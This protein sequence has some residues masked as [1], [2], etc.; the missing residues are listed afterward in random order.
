M[1]VQCVEQGIVFQPIGLFPAEQIEGLL[2]LWFSAGPETS[3]GFGQQPLLEGCN[4]RKIDGL[5]RRRGQIGQVFLFQVI[6]LHQQLRT[7]EQRVAGKCGAGAV[8][9]V[10]VARWSQG[11]NLPDLL[12]GVG[13]KVDKTDGFGTEVADTVTAGQAGRMKQ[14]A[15]GPAL[16]PAFR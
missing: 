14:H 11:Q 10:A 3:R 6:S 16:R 12:T 7:D 8:G 13:Q 15:A 4:G 1:L 5:I 9:G 2:S